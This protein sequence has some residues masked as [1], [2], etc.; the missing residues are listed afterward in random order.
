MSQHMWMIS[1][2]CASILTTAVGYMG[3]VS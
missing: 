3:R 2:I 1:N